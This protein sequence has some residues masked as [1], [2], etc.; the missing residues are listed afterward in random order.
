ML[1]AA[2]EQELRDAQQAESQL[3]ELK[4]KAASTALQKG[5]LAAGRSVE[6]ALPWYE[7]AA[8]LDPGSADVQ[9]G[10]SRL[11]K[12]TGNLLG[13]FEAAQKAFAGTEDQQTRALALDGMDQV[14][15][16]KSDATVVSHEALAPPP[17]EP[18]PEPE[19]LPKSLAEITNLLNADPDNPDLQRDLSIAYDEMGDGHAE[20]DNLI[21]ALEC[22]EASIMIVGRL[23]KAYPDEI[24]YLRDFFVCQEKIGEIQNALGNREAA[25]AAYEESLPIVTMLANRFPD[26][27]ENLFDLK[28][29]KDRLAELKAQA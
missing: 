18:E 7:K 4:A 14:I 2:F 12:E 21:G 26:E 28:I 8:E 11:Y 25:I 20:H 6:E 3:H 24:V 19:P 29:T 16:A 23:A 10:L 1:T 5:S 17:V 22:F 15:V 13:A 9:L 27:E